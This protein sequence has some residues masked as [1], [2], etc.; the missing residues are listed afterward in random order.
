MQ[1]WKFKNTMFQTGV[2]HLH[3]KDK[4][5]MLYT[6]QTYLQ[7]CHNSINK[8]HPSNSGFN[9]HK[10]IRI[11]KKNKQTMSLRIIPC[12]EKYYLIILSKISTI[13]MC[14]GKNKPLFQD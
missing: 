2:N 7:T 5:T 8:Q 4:N 12:N 10:N 3:S 14:S 6:S 11:A 1:Y 9:K 13:Q